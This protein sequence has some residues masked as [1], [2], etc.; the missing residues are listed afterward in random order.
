MVE[1]L[2]GFSVA[3][4]SCW[5]LLNLF[6][7]KTPAGGITTGRE[8]TWRRPPV[9]AVETRL[10]VGVRRSPFRYCFYTSLSYFELVPQREFPT[11]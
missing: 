1:D 3:G 8:V 6:M 2:A 9:G 7:V 10:V 4:A 11:C 5:W